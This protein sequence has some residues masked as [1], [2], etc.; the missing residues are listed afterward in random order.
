MQYWTTVTILSAY[1]GSIRSGELRWSLG[2]LSVEIL[3]CTQKSLGN[4]SICMW[5]SQYTK[6]SQDVC[7]VKLVNS[8]EE[9]YRAK[10]SVQVW[11]KAALN[12]WLP[13]S[14]YAWDIAEVNGQDVYLVS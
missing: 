8:R 9:N 10:S 14:H 13:V 2:S 5:F 12:E 7:V 11:L 3:D 1:L 6:S 4:W